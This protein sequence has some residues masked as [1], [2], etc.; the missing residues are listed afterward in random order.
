MG[1]CRDDFARLAKDVRETFTEE[2]H[3]H[4]CE[5]SA[6]RLVLRLPDLE[7]LWKDCEDALAWPERNA[8]AALEFT[9]TDGYVSV[10]VKHALADNELDEGENQMV[11]FLRRRMKEFVKRECWKG[12]EGEGEAAAACGKQ[13]CAQRVRKGI[14][15]SAWDLCKRLRCRSG[16]HPESESKK[17]LRLKLLHGK[18]PKHMICTATVMVGLY[19]RLSSRMVES[20]HYCVWCGDSLQ[21]GRFWPSLC[22]RSACVA[23]FERTRRPG[24]LHLLVT[25]P[26]TAG[27]LASWAKAAAEFFKVTRHKPWFYKCALWPGPSKPPEGWVSFCEKLMKLHD[28]RPELSLPEVEA[29]LVAVDPGLPASLAW[30]FNSFRGRLTKLHDVAVKSLFKD[31]VREHLK[32]LKVF[33][34]YPSSSKR[35]QAWV[36][37]LELE[38][39]TRSDQFFFHGSLWPKWHGITREDLRDFSNTKH[40]AFTRDDPANDPA[41]VYMS[42]RFRVSAEYCSPHWVSRRLTCQQSCVALC[43]VVHRDRIARFDDPKEQV[44]TDERDVL[45]HLLIVFDEFPEGIVPVDLPEI[46]AHEL[47]AAVT[48]LPELDK[49]NKAMC[50]V[51]SATEADAVSGIM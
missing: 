15:A 18:A 47:A 10:D 21:R 8:H 31:S 32:G 16:C 39:S 41:G 49:V 46:Q 26:D 24:D 45:V 5:V 14:F 42:R 20:G 29:A 33:L 4:L 17:C 48:S 35:M 44:A 22:E 38:A 28:L 2:G 13:V 1:S 19:R 11:W 50:C 30:V 43:Q 25:D 34:V 40:E 37:R 3:R 36:D 9:H 51:T 27:L 6:G 12:Q 23:G 7:G